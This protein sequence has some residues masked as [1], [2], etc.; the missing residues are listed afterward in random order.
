MSALGIALLSIV[1]LLAGGGIGFYLARLGQAAETAKLEEV[2]TEFDAYRQQVTEHFGKTAD[3]FHAIGQQYRELYEHLAEGS[4]ALC[5][6]DAVEPPFPL[7]RQAEPTLAVE[8]TVGD[9]AIAED[10]AE[11]LVGEQALESAEELIE[12]VGLVAAVAEAEAEVEEAV[13]V[14][15]AE[16][17]DEEK[18][19]ELLVEEAEVEESKSD[20]VVAE[21]ELVEPNAEDADAETPDNVVELIPKSED[22][23]DEGT[24]DSERSIR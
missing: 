17:T 2:E 5:K 18:A 19:A 6:L 23:E 15:A 7:V 16:G 12:D 8:E 10:M 9:D 14:V 13:D 22:S 11:D 1:L 21:A 4:Q 20:D 3:Q 24:K